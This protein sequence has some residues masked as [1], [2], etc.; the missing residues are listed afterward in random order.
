MSN[1]PIKTHNFSGVS[2]FR[3]KPVISAIAGSLMFTTGFSQAELLEET[4]VTAQKREQSLQDVGI[5]V[6]AFTGD[7]LSTLGVTESFDIAA[8]SPGVHISGN[9]AGQNTQFTIRGVTQNDFNDIVEAPNAVYLDEGYLAIA[10][11][12][13]FAVFD[14]DRVEILKGPQGTLFGRNAT[15]GLVHYISRKPNLEEAE[16]YVD[17]TYGQFDTGADADQ[18][19][20]EAAVGG[21]LTSQ[22]AG[23]VALMFNKHDGYLENLYPLG[24][25]G[26]ASVGA[27]TSNSP[28]PGA[29]A[30][31]GDDD[32]QAFRGSLLFAFND[33]M[34]LNLSANFANSEVA[35]GPYQSKATVGVLDAGGELID[36]IDAAAGEIRATIAADGS[37]GGSDQGNGGTLGPP[38]GRPVPGGDFFGYI[39]PDGDDFTTSGDF[40]FEDNGETET[41]GINAKYEWQVSDGLTFTSITDY[42]DYE[43]LLFI[44]VDSAPVNQ[45]ANY[46]G[47]DAS[48]FTQELRFT[49]ETESTRWVAGFFYLNIDSESD[50]GLKAPLNSLPVVFGGFPPA[51]AN[52]VDIGVDAELQT[53]SFS[54]F[55]QLETDLSEQLTFIAGLRV[56]QEEKD[57]DMNQ[58]FYA[59]TGNDSVHDG[60]VL[61]SGRAAPFKDDSSDT[62]WAGKLQ[63][64][65]RPNDDL[66]LY[67]GVNR[68]VKA[69]SFNAPIPGGLPFPD[70]ALPYD[71]EVLTS[72]EAGFKATL[73]GGTTRLNG[74]AFYYDYKDYQAFLF[75]GVSGVVVNA[76][77]E[78]QGIELELQTS[79]IDG[80]DILLNFSWF[81]A[82]VKDVPFRIGSP[83]APEDRDPTYAPELQAMGLVRYQWP[84]FN[85]ML[86]IQ[87]DVSYSDEYF[88]NL[89]NFEADKFDSYV[90]ANARLAWESDG[91]QWETA[92]AVRN[93]TDERAGIQGFDLATL[94][95]CNEVSYRAPR[96]YGV[97]VKY[98]F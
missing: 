42:K 48:S 53:D 51:G 26:A 47:V 28:G 75:T 37:D 14:I 25:F 11:A 43:K 39:D 58:T 88:Y 13:T 62:L 38:F 29:G 92:L 2:I 33:A 79:P 96:W 76:D 97:N 41:A 82:T 94:C 5:A 56:I 9:L 90:M 1:W 65:W 18:I 23:R 52:G 49:G 36:V 4:I 7:Q 57:F 70:T 17:F 44:D 64:D 10:Q 74:S 16:G 84:A 8:F 59:S 22:L 77:A 60:E 12:Q 72:F 34:S 78:N 95:G 6:T 98:S 45:L 85:G 71:E 21:P 32:T 87:G 3:R 50:N 31:L 67:A 68:G 89:R 20:I 63:L 93:F 73:L 66:L 46:A 30:D 19:R 86:S 61:F 69:G 80:L 81:D 54:L 55:G 27:G 15:G 40:A 83:L 24:E 91:G 35:T